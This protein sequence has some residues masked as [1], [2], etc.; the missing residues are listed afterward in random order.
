MANLVAAT[1]VEQPDRPPG[2]DLGGRSGFGQT[3]PSP[4]LP[5]ANDPSPAGVVTGEVVASVDAPAHQGRLAMERPG[6]VLDQDGPRWRV[7][8]HRTD[9]PPSAMTTSFPCC[10]RTDT[11]TSAKT[12]SGRHRA[13]PWIRTPPNLAA[14]A[15]FTFAA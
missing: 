8:V 11:N 12:A 5:H 1:R 4:Q 7:A 9:R 13:V 15:R 3:V 2:T 10:C 14:F 6:L